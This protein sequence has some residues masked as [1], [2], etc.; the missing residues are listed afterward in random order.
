MWTQSLQLVLYPLK[1]VI[2]K[3]AKLTV[4]ETLSLLISL[5]G[6]VS[7]L[8]IYYQ[9]TQTSA[10]LEA[11]AKADIKDAYANIGTFTLEVD[12]IFI[13]YPKL[14]PYFYDGKDITD[15]DTNYHA[16]MGMAE[17]QLDFFD[18]TLTQL[19]MKP[20]EDAAEMEAEERLWAKYFSKSF[21]TSRVLCKRYADDEDWYRENLKKYAS[22]PCKQWGFDIE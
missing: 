20:E 12:K 1:W 9:V 4:Y 2:S 8:F 21:A 14:R 17:M 16:V 7:L 15:N 22:A 19:L 18:A 3:L 11:S 5:L 10:S 6:S 13:E